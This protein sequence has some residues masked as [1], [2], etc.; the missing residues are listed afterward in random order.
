MKSFKD[1]RA[2]KDKNDYS[3]EY[4]KKHRRFPVGYTILLFVLVLLQIAFILV[5][6]FYEP[7]PQDKIENY[8]VTVTPKEDGT[9]DIEYDITW[10]ALDA[11]EPLTWVTVGIAN[12]N[13]R[14]YTDSISDNIR[15][16][17][18]DTEDGYVG[19]RLDLHGA[20]SDGD[21]IRLRFTVNQGDILCRAQDGYFYEFVPGWFNS[22]PVEHYEFR[23]AKSKHITEANA[24]SE[25]NYYI[26]S[27][28]FDC[29]EYA[30]MQVSYSSK[31]FEGCQTVS[32]RAFNDDEAYN[33]LYEDKVGLVVFMIILILLVV[34]GEVY[35]ID[36]YVSYQRGRGFLSGYGH[37][38]HV[39]GRVNPH[40]TRA[41]AINS[42]SGSRGGGRG[43]ACACACACAGG[44]R[45]GCS[46]KD[47]YGTAD[48]KYADEE[49]DNG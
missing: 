5:A 37:R 24:E 30:K 14:I 2:K 43:C 49:T 35:I 17:S 45:A 18:L 40:Y 12:P 6:V 23:W 26:W 1:K 27:G 42:S 38:V 11:D 31:A 33:E 41:R 29:G 16:Y 46:Q 19:I 10:C 13:V 44:G 22:I 20:Y 32:H 36:G 48:A 25:G 7:S 34:I 3:E 28:S 8:A 47:T 21:V 9:L 15:K 39:Y 4:V